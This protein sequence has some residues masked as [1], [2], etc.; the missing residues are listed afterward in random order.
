MAI[1]TYII[2]TVDP[3]ASRKPNGSDH[4]HSAGRSTANGGNVTLAFD[5]TAVGSKSI[6][7][8]AVT[9]MLKI[10]DGGNELT[11]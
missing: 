4:V 11:T 1:D 6:L 3:S 9:Q 2:C 7:R 10:V 5:R 8:T